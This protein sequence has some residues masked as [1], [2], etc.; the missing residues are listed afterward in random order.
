MTGRVV[1]DLGFR[2]GDESDAHTPTPLYRV[3]SIP[4][5]VLRSHN[6]E[7]LVSTLNVIVPMGN[8]VASTES[9]AESMLVPKLQ[10]T[11]A[12]GT[13]VPYPVHKTLILGQGLESAIA[14]GKFSS[15]AGAE[16]Q[17]MVKLA[18]ELPALS[19]E[20]DAS[21]QS[22]TAAIN[23]EVGSKAIATFR[24]SIQNSLAYEHGWFR[25][26]LPAL[27]NW[28]VQDMHAS[29]LIKPTMKTFIASI[30]DDVEAKITKE[31]VAQ[32]Q[33]IASIPKN[34]DI[35]ASITGHLDIWAEQSHTE[36]RD[37]LDEGFSSKNWN[38]LSWWKLFWRVDDVTMLSSQM[39]E[40]RWLV[41]AEKSSIYLAGRMNQAGFPDDIRHVSGPAP[42]IQDEPTEPTTSPPQTSLSTS[43]LTPSPWPTHITTARTILIASMVPPLQ[44]LAQRLLLQTFSTTALSSAATALLYISMPTF[45]LF[46][47]SAVAALGLTI[48]LRRMQKLWEGARAQWEGEVRE[49]GRR[50]LKET[51]EVVRWIVESG[52]VGRDGD[53]DGLG[54]DDGVEE[55]RRARVAV[56]R[57]REILGE[58]DRKKSV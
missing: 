19:E 38:K 56:K 48:S 27:S 51:E 30:V 32:L 15:D 24:E 8:T 26:G 7:I 5:R 35:T 11:S 2:Y 28:L 46:E 40:R 25:S 34:D 54:R 23:T 6:L 43:F 39:L 55:R 45:S 41:S 21:V 33:K 44:A 50:T 20:V 52:V 9:S 13:P 42:T 14:F 29:D 49:E 58:V 16:L 37:Q 36:L 4:S 18:V 10:A 1:A 12:R 22:A 31:D 3:L 17:D 57:V 47:A 53:L